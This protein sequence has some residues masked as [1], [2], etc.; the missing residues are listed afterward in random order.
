MSVTLQ[1]SGNEITLTLD[2][3]LTL[4]HAEEL[5]TFLIKAIID[6]NRIFVQL[7]DVADVDLSC[8]QLLCSAHRSAARMNRHVSFSGKWPDRF[9]QAVRDAGYTRLT[10]C[11]LDADHSCLWTRR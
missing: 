2:G 10:G 3:D 4:N 7:G 1:Q 8:L 5:R 9:K 6:S 11:S